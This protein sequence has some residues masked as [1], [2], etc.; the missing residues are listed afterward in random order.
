MQAYVFI[1][2]GDF[3]RIVCKANK[4]LKIFLTLGLFSKSD[5]IAML[6]WFLQQY[7]TEQGKKKKEPYVKCRKDCIVG[8]LPFS[9]KCQP[10]LPSNR[11]DPIIHFHLGP[12]L[13]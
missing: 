5:S 11:E 1:S 9:H 8:T 12:F 10:K 13:S 2:T 6:A 3:F 7:K 4:K